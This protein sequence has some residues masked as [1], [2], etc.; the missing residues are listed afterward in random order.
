MEVVVEAIESS[1]DMQFIAKAVRTVSV[2]FPQEAF[3]TA[4]D[5]GKWSQ[6]P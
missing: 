4:T 1:K 3:A 2:W 5:T 6:L